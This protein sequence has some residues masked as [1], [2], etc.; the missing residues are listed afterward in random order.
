LFQQDT[1][2][3]KWMIRAMYRAKYPEIAKMMD[4]VRIHFPQAKLVKVRDMLGKE[5]KITID[6]LLKK[7]RKPRK[8]R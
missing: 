5:I 1:E 2:Q 4:Q 3:E 7:R 8:R 6:D